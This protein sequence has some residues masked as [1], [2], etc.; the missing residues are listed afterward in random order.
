MKFLRL[1][2]ALALLFPATGVRLF[3]AGEGDGLSL[4]DLGFKADQL[5]SDPAA[6]ATLHK[7]SKML[8][9][10]QI[11]GLVT[12]VPM[13]ASVMTASGAAEGTDSKRDLHKNLGITTGVLY[14]TTASFSLLAP[15][16]EAK[17]SAGATK[18]HKGLAWIHFPAM[19][20]A[21]ILGYQA[22]QQRDKGEDVHGAAKHHATVAGVGAAAYFLSMAVMVFNF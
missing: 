5:K 13:L 6:Q 10:H 12:A 17:K 1:L 15:E 8:K 19:V 9:T 21:P 2:L 20:I 22:Y 3:A 18:I 16:G 14:F 11:L 7:R 4:D